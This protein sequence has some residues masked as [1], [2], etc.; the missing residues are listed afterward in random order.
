M[1]LSLY[2]AEVLIVGA[3]SYLAHELGHVVVARSLG[4]KVYGIGFCRWGPYAK[5]EVGDVRNLW[6]VALAGPAVS[7][8]IAGVAF[9]LM[10]ELDSV[11]FALVFVL[12]ALIAL[13]NLIPLKITDGAQ[14][15]R[16][17]RA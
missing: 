13:S 3:L 16:S 2:L 10:V 11:F 1:S 8:L 5:V 7:M 17:F 9:P 14:A 15:L 4:W 12:N 6:R